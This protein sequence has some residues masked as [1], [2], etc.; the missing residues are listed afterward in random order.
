VVVKKKFNKKVKLI[1]Y[2]GIN[3]VKCP[4]M[5]ILW[6]KIQNREGEPNLTSWK[7]KQFCYNKTS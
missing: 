5:I 4:L 1:N 2:I 6:I 7:N 3:Q